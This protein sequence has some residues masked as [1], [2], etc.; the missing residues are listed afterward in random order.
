MLRLKC[1][2]Q[3]YAWGRKPTDTNGRK[4]SEVSCCHHQS[5]LSHH[6][7]ALPIGT[8]LGYGGNQI[9]RAM[10]TSSTPCCY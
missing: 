7:S 10:H 6:E 1:P 9:R 3:N 4:G 5:G 2:A 8:D